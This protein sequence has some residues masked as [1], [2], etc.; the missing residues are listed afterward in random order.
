MQTALHILSLVKE[1]ERQ[2]VGGT[3]RS[4]EFYRKQRAAYFFIKAAKSTT[5]LAFLF[6]PHGSG[7]FCVP[8]SKVRPEGPEKPFPVFKL[9]GATITGLSQLGLDRILRFDLEKAGEKHVI[10]IEALG[11][12][13]NI[14]LLDNH[15]RRQG[16]LRHRDFRDGDIYEPPPTGD[17]LDPRETNAAIL[18][19]RLDSG[20][21]PSMVTFLEKNIIGF[22]RTLAK[23]SVH[24][25][26][27][28]FTDINDV[29][30]DDLSA[31]AG[32]ITDIAGR[33]ESPDNGYLYRT[34]SGVEVYPFKLSF[35]DQQPEKYKTLSLA[36]QAMASMRQ[37]QIENADEEKTVNDA[38]T[39]AVKRLERRLANLEKDLESAA[40]F[41]R[42]K[43]LGELLQIN[44]SMISKGQTQVEV[45]D[46]YRDPPEKIVIPLDQ[47]LSPHENA[48]EYFKKHRK[49]R[50]GLELLQRRLQITRDELA[51]LRAMQQALET[52]FDSARLR[53]D[54]EIESL[55]PREGVKEADQQRLPYKEYTLA[56]GV[57]I[58]VG[59]DGTDND[60]T[61]FDFARPY[62]L[63]FHTQ[64]CPGS[65]VVIK[66][67]NK[68]FEPSKLEIEMTAAIAAWFSKARN[69]SLVPVIYTERRY[70]RKPR[71]AKPGLVTVEREK[72]VMVEPQKPPG[73]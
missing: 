4:T 23:E 52:N 61:T 36:V 57:K 15:F 16:V 55:L 7:T 6:H 62:E 3:I 33:F 42:Y 66:Y 41:E 68:S 18:R 26:D 64:Q 31:I 45:D 34:A 37:E 25:A 11:P 10:V 69:D 59:R 27:L 50:E 67:P 71:K 28:D 65:H 20:Q 1:L 51:E 47:K 63:W 9:E 14:W 43:K 54:S 30:D 24:R 44:L 38:V 8:A 73:D 35:A 2:V 17:R 40:D 13:G 70:V 58:F 29:S 53:Y 19:D 48:R 39:R 12:N 22:N 46:I 72:S 60:R 32:S 5:A 49:G 56:T 21:W